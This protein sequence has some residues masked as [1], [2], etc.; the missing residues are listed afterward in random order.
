M[1]VVKPE[2]ITSLSK[3]F[4]CDRCNERWLHKFRIP[5][6]LTYSSPVCDDEFWCDFCRKDAGFVTPEEIWD[7]HVDR[8]VD[9]VA[10]PLMRVMRKNSDLNK[11]SQDFL[12][13]IISGLILFGFAE[14]LNV[15]GESKHKEIDSKKME[16]VARRLQQKAIDR[17]YNCTSGQLDQLTEN[18]IGPAVEALRKEQDQETLND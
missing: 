11:V 18:L 9:V 16:E 12:G 13:Q 7:K 4:K 3:L 1:F 5:P 15:C 10:E 8:I 14:T 17:T 2:P 6:I